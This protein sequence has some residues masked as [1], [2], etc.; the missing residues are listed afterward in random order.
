MNG[1]ASPAYCQLSKLV[2]LNLTSWSKE[3]IEVFKDVV[4]YE[5]VYQVSDKGTVKS[6]DRLSNTRWGLRTRKGVTLKQKINDG[7]YQCVHLR[8]KCEE[9]ESWPPVHR[10][11]A[12]AFIPNLD[13]KPTVNHKDGDKSN[14]TVDNLEWSTHQE[15]TVHAF[16]NNLMMVRGNTL[17]DDDFKESVK[18]YFSEN[19]ISIKKLGKLFNISETT[20]SRIV[21]GK[22]GDPRKSD[23]AIVSKAMWLRE[24]GYT[25]TR[26]GE[27]VG[28]NFS[29]VHNW[30]LKRGLVEHRVN[31][32]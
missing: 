12:E 30:A 23:K 4:G 7:G 22:Y 17:Y 13:N 16:K 31:Y 11:V 6:L 8:W 19:S 3:M 25:L 24:Q 29:T 1:I 20:A 10:L 26:I 28:K 18:K 32:E 5:G 9:K 27:I 21:K 14:N 15:Q 2:S